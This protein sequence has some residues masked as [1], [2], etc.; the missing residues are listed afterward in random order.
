MS[1]SPSTSAVR[2]LRANG[3]AYTEHVYRYERVLN[4]RLVDA[5]IAPGA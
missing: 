2:L 4:P 1:K 3:V 5:A